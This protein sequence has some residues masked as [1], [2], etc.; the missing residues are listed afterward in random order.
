MLAGAGLSPKKWPYAIYHFLQ[1][2]NVCHTT[3]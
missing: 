1:L 3:W 2:Y